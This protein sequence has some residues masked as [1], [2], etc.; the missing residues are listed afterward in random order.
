MMFFSNTQLNRSIS[1]SIA[2]LL[3]CLLISTTAFSHQESPTMEHKQVGFSQQESVRLEDAWVRLAPKNAKVL[4]LFGGFYNQTTQP[5]EIISATSPWFERIELHRTQNINGLMK[6]M[7]Q[8]SMP[9]PPQGMLHL[10]PRSWH[11][12]LIGPKDA[13]QSMTE[14]DSVPIIINFSNGDRLITEVPI[15]QGMS[16]GMIHQH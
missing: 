4:A 15:K 8:K 6:M 14:A 1:N 9:I 11:M 13:Q 16:K 2:I 5:V 12:M 10:K 7:L 3:G